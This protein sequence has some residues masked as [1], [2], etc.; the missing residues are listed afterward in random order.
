MLQKNCK[1]C[2]L[3]IKEHELLK[4]INLVSYT[5][6][7]ILIILKVF[8]QFSKIARFTCRFRRKINFIIFNRKTLQGEHILTAN[9]YN[10]E[11]NSRSNAGNHKAILKIGQ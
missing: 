2:T 8:L 9:Y 5:F 11:Q 3:K 1:L 10:D 4:R 6:F 7:Y